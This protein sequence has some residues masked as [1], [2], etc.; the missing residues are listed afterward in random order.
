MIK[1]QIVDLLLQ[2]D[3]FLLIILIMFG[4]T[5][6]SKAHSQLYIFFKYSTQSNKILSYLPTRLKQYLT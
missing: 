3:L 4:I 1:L 6:F 2:A 5:D